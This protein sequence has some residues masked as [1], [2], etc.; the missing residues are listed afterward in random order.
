MLIWSCRY[1]QFANQY[2]DCSIDIVALAGVDPFVKT[3][4][5]GFLRWFVLPSYRLLA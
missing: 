4:K 1:T 5:K 2:L 3:V